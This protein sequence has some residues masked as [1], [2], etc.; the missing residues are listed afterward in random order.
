MSSAERPSPPLSPDDA[1]PPVEPP[2]AGFILQLF[3]IPAVIVA[4]VVMVWLMFTWLAQKG[5]DPAAYVAALERNNEARWQAAVNLAT[6]LK[7][8]GN[9]PDSLKRDTKLANQLAAIL[10]AE[11]DAG[12]SQENSINLRV[13]LCRALGEFLVADGAGALARAASTNRH[14]AETAVRRAALEALA[15]LAH[16]L[17][18]QFTAALADDGPIVPVLLAAAGDDDP[19]VRSPAAFALGVVGTP[20]ALE[21]L[22]RG[23]DD[24][25]P[26]VRYN[27]ATGL[28][29]HGRAAAEP[30]LLEMLDPSETAGMEVEK[31]PEVRAYKRA[32]ITTNGL[33]AARELIDNNATYDPARLTSAVQDLLKTELASDVRAE[34]KATLG[35]LGHR[36][37][38]PR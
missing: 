1:L 16:N 15:V 10:T 38:A 4:I 20:L 21:R 14:E 19:L 36:P 7:D 30:V 3:I 11:L 25:Y 23:V 32:L 5:N 26:D 18:D 37:A 28:A 2:S 13:F 6:A 24:P 29:R 17:R 34:A 27:A 9:G 12:S 8:A 35:K 33:R 22:E 31:L